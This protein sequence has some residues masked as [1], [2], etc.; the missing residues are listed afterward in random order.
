[1]LIKKALAKKANAF[2]LEKQIIRGEN[3]KN[4]KIKNEKNVEKR[5]YMLYNKN[6][7]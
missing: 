6:S 4:N 2:L 3:P 1:M 7:R 5:L